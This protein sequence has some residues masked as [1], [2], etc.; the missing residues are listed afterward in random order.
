MWQQR[1]SDRGGHGRRAGGRR[2]RSGG[3]RGSP[4]L[5]RRFW[6]SV[7]WVRGWRGFVRHRRRGY[8][9]RRGWSRDGWRFGRRRPRRCGR[10]RSSRHRWIGRRGRSTRGGRI[11]R[12]RG[13]LRSGWLGWRD[14]SRRVGHHLQRRLLERHQRQAHRSARRRLHSGGRHLVL[15][16]RGQVDELG[17]LLRRQH[18]RLEGPGELAV[19]QRDHHP[20]DLDGSRGRR[21]DHRAPQDH[22]QRLDPAVRDVAALGRR[23]ATRRRRRASSPRPPSTATT[24][25]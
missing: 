22:L 9:R 13:W 23:R 17:Q 16:R 8:D 6:W 10:G 20:A 21:S 14:G 18:L 1:I 11:G 2:L 19:P 7:R 12:R 24:S 25:R 3:R 4:R 15:G 5:W